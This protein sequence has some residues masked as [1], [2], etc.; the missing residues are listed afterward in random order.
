MLSV[1]CS[2]GTI[3]TNYGNKYFECPS[4]VRHIMDLRVSS[5]SLNLSH[6]SSSLFSKNNT[7]SILCPVLMMYTKKDNYNT[8]SKCSAK[9]VSWEGGLITANF[10][11]PKGTTWHSAKLQLT[12]KPF[13]SFSELIS[14]RVK[15]EVTDNNTN[16]HSISTTALVLHEE[17]SGTAPA[18]IMHPPAASMTQMVDTRLLKN[19]SNANRTKTRLLLKWEVLHR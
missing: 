14:N 13:F 3:L 4:S 18:G 16:S 17:R 6:V 7:A 11:R 15:Q 2:F 10:Y 19:I 9:Q 1:L 8:Y 5:P 12:I